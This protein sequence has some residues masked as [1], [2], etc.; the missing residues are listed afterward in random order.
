MKRGRDT[1]GVAVG[2]ISLFGFSKNKVP[3]VP[4]LT[5]S[6]EGFSP[7]GGDFSMYR[8][9]GRQVRAIDSGAKLFVDSLLGTCACDVNAIPPNVLC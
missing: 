7:T 4:L 2:A 8:G 9:V 3:V 6:H 5:I 1:D